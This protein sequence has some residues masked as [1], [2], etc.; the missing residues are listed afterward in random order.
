MSE[1]EFKAPPVPP[2]APTP[3]F[4]PKEHPQENP[5]KGLYDDNFAAELNLPAKVLTTKVMAGVMFGVLLF[6]MMLGSIFFGGSVS[7]GQK[8]EAGLQGVVRNIDLTERLPR[9]G[10]AEK[11]QA[12][13][14]YIMNSS[15]YDKT[16]EDFFN[17]VVRLM[18]VSH[19]SVSMVNSRY[20]KQRIKP[21][22]IAQ[23][24]VPAVR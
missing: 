18:E 6:G 2:K 10:I 5:V 11:G 17:E 22:Y 24:K 14:L 9:C 21:G 16:A 7:S 8:Q 4:M 23:I 15:K 19:Y 3:V 13:L 1:N 20:A 12:C